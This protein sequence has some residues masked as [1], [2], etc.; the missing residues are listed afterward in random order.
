MKTTNIQGST[1]QAAIYLAEMF[2]IIHGIIYKFQK[3]MFKL[4]KNFQKYLF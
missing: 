4:M 3:T 1:P 2:M